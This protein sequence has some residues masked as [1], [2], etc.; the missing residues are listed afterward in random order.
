LFGCGCGCGS[1]SVSVCGCACVRLC[2]CVGVCVQADAVECGFP[3]CGIVPP[4]F[5]H[6]QHK[7]CQRQR[8]THPAASPALHMI[9]AHM[10]HWAR[11]CMQAQQAEGKRARMALAAQQTEQMRQAGAEVKRQ[12]MAAHQMRLA[13]QVGSRIGCRTMLCV[14]VRVCVCACAR[15]LVCFRR[16]PPYPIH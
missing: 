4:Q 3:A 13:A 15:A 7:A 9:D 1:V 2:V 5:L 12:R 8:H 6:T 14:E 16:S 10:G 11:T